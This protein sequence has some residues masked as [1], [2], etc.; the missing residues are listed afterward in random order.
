MSDDGFKQLLA[1]EERAK[2]IVAAVRKGTLAACVRRTSSAL[3]VH[4]PA[5]AT[6]R[7]LWR[8]AAAVNDVA[9]VTNIDDVFAVVRLRYCRASAAVEACRGRGTSRHRRVS[10]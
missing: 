4:F 3:H 2:E 10:R 1:A 6:S 7:A 5:R 9:S 8:V